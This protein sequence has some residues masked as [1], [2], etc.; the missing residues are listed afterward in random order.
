MKIK[1]LSKDESLGAVTIYDNNIRL[2]KKAADYFI[3]AFAVAIGIDTDSN[4]I[5]IKN[6]SKEEAESNRFDKSR[7]HK[8]AIKPNYGRITGKQ[9]IDELKS[10]FEFDFNVK[11]A[12]KYSARWNTGDKL[13]IVEMEE[14]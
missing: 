6:V 14:C 5:I 8:I 7:L 12:Y 9:I 11:Q 13:L 2:S 1:W 3:D 10:I 4:N